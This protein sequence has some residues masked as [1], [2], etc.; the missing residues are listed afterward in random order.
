[1]RCCVILLVIAA[2]V[3]ARSA[4]ARQGYIAAL[5]SFV[6]AARATKDPA[7]VHAAQQG[8]VAAYA[9]VGGPTNAWLFFQRTGG[10]GAFAM[11]A[12]LATRYAALEKYSESNEVYR[13]MTSLHPASVHAC[14]WQANVVHNARR[15][16]ERREQLAEV[17]RLL[18]TRRRVLGDFTVPPE[19]KQA[20][21]RTTRD[22]MGEL[23]SRW[24]EALTTGC[25]AYSWPDW[26]PL[27]TL[28]REFLAAF[29]GDPDA[30]RVSSWLDDLLSR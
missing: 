1:M 5:E 18:A 6:S 19:Q 8:I 4:T 30:P 2:P 13:Q 3:G 20:C 9:H 26:P 21:S 22:L 15:F 16:A 11:L 17:Q 7:G 10:Q 25:T 29:P 23:V 14:E 12:E 27:E 24:K 28:L